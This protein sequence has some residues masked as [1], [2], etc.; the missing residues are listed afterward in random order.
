M[1]PASKSVDIPE[2]GQLFMVGLPGAVV[3]DSTRRLIQNF[4][5]NNFIY[6][7]R[8]VESPEQIKQLSKDLC[9]ACKES[10]LGPPLIAIDQE[11]G[12]VTRLPE[13][14]SQ[15][16]D[17]KILAGSTEPEKALSDYARV[18]SREL[19]SIGVNY[20]LAPVLDVCVPGK[21]YFMEKRSLGGNPENVGRFGRVVIR[22]LQANGIG[23]CAKHFPGLGTAVVDPHFQL[24][25]V[26]KTEECIRSEDLPPFQEAIAIGV[27]SIMTSHTIYNNLDPENPATLSKKILTGLLRHDL[28]YE[29]VV[30][31]DDLEMGAIEQESDVGHAAVQAFAAGADLLLIC[32]SHQKVIDAYNKT[33]RAVD[34]DPALAGRMAA[35]L[36]RLSQ[37]RQRFAPG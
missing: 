17:A 9:L 37:M 33:A 2:L 34:R 21:E 16:P 14:F 4:G 7:S 36:Q 30:I 18:C 24:P 20:N 19:R 8:N 22:E 13:P 6:F 10:G 1:T 28:G 31:T 25:F 15:F 11:G 3:D 35:S 27:A 23:A 26:T 32:K 29:G 12:S 5:I